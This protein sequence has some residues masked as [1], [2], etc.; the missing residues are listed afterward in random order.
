MHAA[1]FKANARPV[2]TQ[3]NFKRTKSRQF[4]FYRLLAQ[5]NTPVSTIKNY[6]LIF[7]MQNIYEVLDNIGSI[8]HNAARRQRE[9]ESIRTSVWWYLSPTSS[10]SSP[11]GRLVVRSVSICGSKLAQLRLFGY[12]K[13]LRDDCM[14]G[15]V[16]ASERNVTRST[17][18]KLPS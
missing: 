9:R 13:S 11:V 12:C 1:P 7:T 15:L 3:K 8:D 18:L 17:F 6:K 14:L 2:L 10:T 16:S 5:R 4:K